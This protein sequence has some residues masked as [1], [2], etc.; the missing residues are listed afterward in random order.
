MGTIVVRRAPRRPAPE[1]PAGRRRGAGAAGDPGAQ[2]GRGGST[3]SR[4]L[5]M[6]LGTVATAL[7]FAGRS[8]DRYSLVIGAIFG[9]STLGHAGHELGQRRRASP[10]RPEL[11]AAAGATTCASSPCCAGRSARP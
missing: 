7:L 9:L 11:M 4:L 6:L 1:L 3:R 8:G 10:R 2:P 5:P